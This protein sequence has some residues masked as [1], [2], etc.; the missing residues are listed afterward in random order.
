MR[1]NTMKILNFTL[2][3]LLYVIKTNR[4]TTESTQTFLKHI[5]KNKA[6]SL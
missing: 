1:F 5:L 2:L 6:I 3:L 4:L